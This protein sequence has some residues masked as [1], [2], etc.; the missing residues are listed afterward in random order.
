MNQAA[1]AGQSEI[2]AEFKTAQS[3]KH[4]QHDVGSNAAM[5]TGS[6]QSVTVIDAT[7]NNAGKCSLHGEGCFRST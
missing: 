6:K 1:I 7:E 3:R 5:L 2:S 4:I